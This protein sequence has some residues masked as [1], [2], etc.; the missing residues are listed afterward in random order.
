M[1]VTTYLAYFKYN[2]NFQF[3]ITGPI[4]FDYTIIIC[5][6]NYTS[7]FIKL[8]IMYTFGTVKELFFT[9]WY[10]IVDENNNFVII[11]LINSL[12]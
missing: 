3:Q 9:L 2:N 12:H 7:R 6:Q 8:M 11:Y 10:H 4:G 5:Y 1:Y